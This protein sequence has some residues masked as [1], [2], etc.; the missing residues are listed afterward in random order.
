[1][2]FGWQTAR[3]T[4]LFLALIVCISLLLTWKADLPV[5]V[6]NLEA[7]RNSVGGRPGSFDDSSHKQ[8][9]YQFDPSPQLPPFGSLVVAASEGLDLSW[10]TQV[11][12]K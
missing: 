4:G 11:N 7:I 8:N 6:N 10:T 12:Q 3:L 1:M 5:S 9:A 2:A